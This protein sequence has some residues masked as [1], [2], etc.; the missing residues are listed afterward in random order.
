V[1]P[2]RADGIVGG[3]GAFNPKSGVCC[4]EC[5]AHCWLPG[6]MPHMHRW[7]LLCSACVL[8]KIKAQRRLHCDC[9]HGPVLAG[10]ARG[11]ASSEAINSADW[12]R[13]IASKLAQ[14]LYRI[15]LSDSI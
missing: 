7:C 2:T 4:P 12:M 1:T 10:S 11:T 8:R 15:Q 5:P 13:R 14:L 9:A 3:I 6:V